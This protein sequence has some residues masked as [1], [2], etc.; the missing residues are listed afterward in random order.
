MVRLGSWMSTLL[1]LSPPPPLSLSFPGL[2]QCRGTFWT[3]LV[4]AASIRSSLGQ[5]MVRTF[6]VKT[7]HLYR[8]LICLPAFLY[9]HKAADQSRQMA[10]QMSMQ[11]QG[12]AGKQ[13][14]SQM[15]KVGLCCWWN[16]VF[17][18]FSLIK[19]EWEA[20]QVVEHK[21]VLAKVEEELI[22]QMPLLSRVPLTDPRR[23]KA[24]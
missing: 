23:K 16:I 21:D 19:A 1:D 14:P 5:I 7:Y 12:A 3:S 9:L 22:S 20:L 4:F 18:S 24:L 10:M 2:A 17:Y 11:Q 13:P 6:R 15:F 8:N